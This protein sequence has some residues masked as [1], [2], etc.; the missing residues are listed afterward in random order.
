MSFA[1]GKDVI[2]QLL[3]SVFQF[4]LLKQTDGNLLLHRFEMFLRNVIA[5]E[6]LAQV[7]DPQSHDRKPVNRAA[8]SFGIHRHSGVG[9]DF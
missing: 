6:L 4:V 7:I 3:Q 1:T 8:G 5:V 9:G 2:K